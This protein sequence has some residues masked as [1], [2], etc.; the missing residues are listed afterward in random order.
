MVMTML[1]ADTKFWS[2][3]VVGDTT[4]VSF[5]KIG[6]D[7]Q[8]QVKSHASTAAAKAF[9]SKM[10]ASKEKKGYSKTNKRKRATGTSAPPV[11]KK[12]PAVKTEKRNAPST[13]KETGRAK[14]KPAR[15]G[16]A[17]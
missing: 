3:K 9:A 10:I 13:K 5:G 7:G 17:S 4:H 12:K 14:K 15:S 8:Q 6:S 2:I 1:E 11:A 16:T